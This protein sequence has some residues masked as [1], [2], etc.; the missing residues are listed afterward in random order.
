MFSPMD[1][2][3]EAST[4]TPREGDKATKG[5]AEKGND[6]EECIQEEQE[7]DDVNSSSWWGAWGG[8]VEA[9]KSTLSKSTEIYDIMKKDIGELSSAVT[10]E[11]KKIVDATTT[12]IRDHLRVRNLDDFHHWCI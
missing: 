12:K 1:G 7:A 9:T 5:V 6:T 4:S 3:S 8:I 10:T 2:Q 11:S